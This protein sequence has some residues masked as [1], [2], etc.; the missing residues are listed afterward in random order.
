MTAT[1][2]STDNQPPSIVTLVLLCALTALSLNMFLPS[3]VEIS[4]DFSTSYATIGAA[5]AAYL[6]FTA[7]LQLFLGPLSDRYGRRPVLLTC[8][9]IFTLASAGCCLS[10]NVWQFMIFRML[11]GFVIGA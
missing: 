3:I 4:E 10:T 6:G 8:I 9:A 11:Q 2:I 1:S 7:L 5:I